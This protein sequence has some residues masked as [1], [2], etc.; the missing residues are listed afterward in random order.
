[1]VRSLAPKRIENNVR[2]APSLES[3]T[4]AQTM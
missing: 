3:S 1:M 4:K 2:M